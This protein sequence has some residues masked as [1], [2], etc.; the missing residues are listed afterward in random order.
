MANNLDE[1]KD[2]VN[3][4]GSDVNVI[5]KQIPVKTG[6]GSVI[7]EVLLWFCVLPGVILLYLSFTGRF[8]YENNFVFSFA[9]LVLGF[10]PPIGFILKKVKAANY[11]MGLEQR[12]QHDASQLDNY[13]EQRV[14]ILKNTAV[15]VQKSVEVDKSV[16]TEIAS[17]R[18]NSKNTDA[19]R[20]ELDGMLM[21]ESAKL[22]AVYENYPELKSH[23]T[24][25]RAMNE[26]SYLQKEITA[27]REVYNDGVLKW[28]KEIFI[29]PTNAIV[30]AKKG[31]TTRIPYALDKETKDA[32]R[33]VFF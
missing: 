7:F 23:E 10:F 25:T 20:A 27:A 18:T 15:L 22:M 12:I 9:V 13:L 5:L 14:Q 16:F 3:A 31:Y 26:N 30:A 4:N 8:V 1:L 11:F 29:W 33:G 2:P 17:I 21:K 19:E 6:A 32:A 24:I 28:N